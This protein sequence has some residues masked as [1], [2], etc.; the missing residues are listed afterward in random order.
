MALVFLSFLFVS[1]NAFQFLHDDSFWI[2]SC[3]VYWLFKFISTSALKV[4]LVTLSSRNMS[5]ELCH[6]CPLGRLQLH[7]SL[8]CPQKKGRS[9][10]NRARLI[11]WEQILLIT[12]R[13]NLTLTYNRSTAISLWTHP[14]LR[15]TSDT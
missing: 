10:G 15:H 14:H 5:Q 3:S 9:G 11:T 4:P 7:H 2:F 1:C 12:S 8:L 13:K 6:T